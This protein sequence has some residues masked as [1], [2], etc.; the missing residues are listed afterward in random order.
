MKT[1][2][3]ST[4]E[5]AR[6]GFTHKAVLSSADGDFSAAAT[7]QA[8]IL[9]VISAGKIVRNAG[10]KIVTNVACTGATSFTGQLG[11]GSTANKFLTATSA[12]GGASPVVYQAGDGAGFNQGG[13]TAATADFNLTF[14]VTSD[15]NIALVT[16]GEIHVY[17][18]EANLLT[19]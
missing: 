17:W 18:A 11:D 10:R 15:V 13:G 12:L 4:E 3:L 8:I 14:T 2:Q 5:R 1:L 6:S 16:A 9:G 19:I 7:S